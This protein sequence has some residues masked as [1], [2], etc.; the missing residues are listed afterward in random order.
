MAEHKNIIDPNIHEPKGVSIAPIN[1]VYTADG[2]GSG[3]WAAINSDNS[4]LVSSEAD[5]PSSLQLADNTNYIIGGNVTL[6]QDYICGAN[7][8]IIGVNGNNC[9]ITYTGT[10][11]AFTATNTNTRFTNITFIGATATSMFKGTGL[12][13]SFHRVNVGNCVIVAPVFLDLT[14]MIPVLSVLNVAGFSTAVKMAGA[15]ILV[16]SSFKV[17]YIDTGDPADIGIDLGTA[18]FR[19]IVLDGSI[20]ISGGTGISGLANSGNLTASGIGSISGCDFQGIAT[21]TINITS[22]DAQWEIDPSNTGITQTR[23]TGSGHI[24]GNALTTTF[25]GLGLANAVKINLGAAFIPGDQ[26]TFTVDNTGTFTYL[27]LQ[28][29]TFYS[30][31]ELFSSIGGGASRQYVYLLNVNGTLAEDTSSKNEY[32]G[33]NPGS[34]SCSGEVTLSQ[35]QTLELWV[36]AVTATTALTVDTLSGKVI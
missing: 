1:T 7:N 6:T 27:G 4:V 24:L 5:M 36:Y 18:T 34:N 33:S 2:A 22:T 10:G 28:S 13:A 19:S 17:A 35:G 3:T 14:N 15:D 11:D 30:S 20:H 16:F 23:R 29:K 9:V 8:G 12:A 25:A 31:F 26:S 21:P 32:D